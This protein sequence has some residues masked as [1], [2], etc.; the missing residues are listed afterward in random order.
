MHAEIHGESVFA[1]SGPEIRRT[2][3]ASVNALAHLA[4]AGIAVRICRSV[5]EASEVMASKRYLLVVLEA[6]KGDCL[7]VRPTR[8]RSVDLRKLGVAL[9]LRID[10]LLSAT[11][12]P[13]IRGFV[14]AIAGTAATPQ[15]F[16]VLVSQAGV[17]RKTLWSRCRRSGVLSPREILQWV[18]IILA[19][20]LLEETVLTVDDVANALDFATPS[21][22]RTSFRR[23]LQASPAGLRTPGSTDAILHEFARRMTP[24][25]SLDTPST[26]PESAAPQL[27]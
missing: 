18:R 4:Q 16:S 3:S 22:L 23:R 7:L 6:K 10:A 14:H 26:K 20:Q 9:R 11:L 2:D 5:A 17:H 12:D 27:S 15:P 8:T 13:A 19:T 24:I 25:S 1:D 21:T